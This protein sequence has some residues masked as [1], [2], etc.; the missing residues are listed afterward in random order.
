MVDSGARGNRQQVRQLAGMRGL[1][2]K[3]RGEIIEQPILSNFREG[4]TV[5][6]YFISTHGA[7]KGLADTALKTADS[8]YLTR[9]LVDASQDVIIHEEDCG[10]ANG[11]IGRADLRRRRRSRRSRDRIV[12][13]VSCE[14]VVD[15][16][17]KKKL[18]KANQ[19]IDEADRRRDRQGRR[20]ARQDPLRAHLRKQARHLRALLRP[21]PGDRPARQARRS[22]RHHRRAVHRR[23]RHAADDAD[24]PHRRHGEPDLQAAADQG[25]ER[26]H[27]AATTTCAPCKSLDGNRIV[28][29]KNGSITIHRRRRPRDSNATTSSSARSSPSPDGGKVKKGETFV[30]WDPYNVPI[31][32][33]KA[34]KVEFHDIIE[35][36]TMK[37][38]S[39]RNDRPGWAWSSSSTRKIC[40]RRSS[41]CGDDGEVVASYSIPAGAHIVVEAKATR[42]VAGTLL[43]K[44]PRKIAKTK[45]IT[46]GLPR[47]AEL[48]EARRPKDAAEIAKIDGIVDFGGTRPR[49]AEA[50][51]SRTPR[52]APKRSISFR[53]ASTSSSSRATS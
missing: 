39:G 28:L 17:T 40:I 27:D 19:L 3:P 53:S 16:V 22:R 48:F 37:Q 33:E 7:R 34:G 31:L 26:R 42:F 12:G 15:P 11:I 25:Q 5:L 8:G 9:K 32:T 18:V 41:S 14:T 36:V 23:T 38:R 24:V 1:M 50:A 44:T 10:T 35:G 2:A 20:R 49:Q 45:D 30:Q 46:G 29:N 4:L 47:V 6:E 52:P 51:F 21:Q 43:A 13:R